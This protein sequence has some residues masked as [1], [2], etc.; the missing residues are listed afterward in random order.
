VFKNAP[1]SVLVEK[2]PAGKYRPPHARNGPSS[3][4]RGGSA[5]TLPIG[6]SQPPSKQQKNRHRKISPNENRPNSAAAPQAAPVKLTQDAVLEKQIRNLTK[7][8]DQIKVLEQ[9]VNNGEQLE[10]NQV[11]FIV[12]LEPQFIYTHLGSKDC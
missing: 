10:A 12:C 11:L 9:R 3:D 7:K 1:Q 6:M 4:S 8:I 2:K 5:P